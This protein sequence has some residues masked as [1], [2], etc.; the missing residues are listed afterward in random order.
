MTASAGATPDMLAHVI[1]WSVPGNCPSV[2]CPGHRVARAKPASQGAEAGSNV[3]GGGATSSMPRR[4]FL[5]VP[6]MN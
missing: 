2:S 1:F 4:L 3:L 5:P 6:P